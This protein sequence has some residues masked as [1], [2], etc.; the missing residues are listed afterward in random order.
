M[1][2]TPYNPD[3]LTKTQKDAETRMAA[4]VGKPGGL[5]DNFDA[6]SFATLLVIALYNDLQNQ[7]REYE[8]A[9]QQEQKRIDS[10]LNEINEL[11]EDNANISFDEVA[12]NPNYKI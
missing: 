12:E 4:Q 10:V 2:I 9:I 6:A 1:I 5:P 8:E 7:S 11:K 3:N